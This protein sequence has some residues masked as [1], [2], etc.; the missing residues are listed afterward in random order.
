MSFNDLFSKTLLLAFFCVT[1]PCCNNVPAPVNATAKINKTDT[2]KSAGNV[3]NSA[4]DDG[5]SGGSD[6][7]DNV[8]LYFTIADTARDYFALRDKMYSL[9]KATNIPIDTMNR[10]YNKEKN[11]I[12]VS[13]DDDDEMYR[14]EY[15]PRR[16]PSL[17]LSLEYY[18][19]YINNSS[20]KNIALVSAI[21]ENKKSAD[22][23]LKIISPFCPHSFV[24][25]AVV[26][27]GCMH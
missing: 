1:L 26:Y 23:M 15:F 27:E 14:G 7:S 6:S 3:T 8:M 18:R 19:T 25:Q 16:F 11:E 2:I 4:T 22:S 21:S 20:A 12:V 24:V 17:N 10:Y 13:D 9:N 5:S